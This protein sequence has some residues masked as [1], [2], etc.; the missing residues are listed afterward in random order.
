MN[1][2]YFS[3]FWDEIVDVVVGGTTYTIS[4]FQ[5]IGNAVAG[6]I[7]SFFDVIVHYITDLFIFLSWFAVSLKNIFLAIL[8][9]ITYFF[10][11]L[12]SF[13]GTAF[14]T[15]S[16]PDITYTFSQDIVDVFEAIPYWSAFGVILGAVLILVIGIS[17]VKLLLNT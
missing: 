17:A 16:T 9:P 10:A 4:W 5:G 3:Q 11:V 15:A 8:S 7:G 13:F 6:A 1:W 12:K 14:G 2:S